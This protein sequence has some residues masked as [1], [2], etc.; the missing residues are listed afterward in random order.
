MARRRPRDLSAA[1]PLLRAA[2]RERGRR[3]ACG[4]TGSTRSACITPQ[5]RATAVDDARGSRSARRW[6][7][8][9]AQSEIEWTRVRSH[10]ARAARRTSTSFD[11]DV[12]QPAELG[13]RVRRAGEPEVRRGRS[14]RGSGTE[15]YA[16]AGTGFHSNDARGA[17]I[18]VDPAT[19]EPRRSRD[20]A[21]AREGRRSRAAHGAHPRAAVDRRAVV[22]R[23]R[24]G[25]ALRRRRRHDRSRPAQPPR[26]RRVDQLRAA[27]AV[28]DGRRRSGV[29]ARAIHATTIRRAATSRARSTASSQPA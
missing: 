28:A 25:T 21:G 18:R 3:S 26:R 17:A 12:R 22:S 4:T 23:S 14:D 20:A 27:A 15:V 1:R 2:R 16:N 29:L 24:L 5:A 19:G 8:S 13:R 10:D 11:V 9:I 6:P 7:A